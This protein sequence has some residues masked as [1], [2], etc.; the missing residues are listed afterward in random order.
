MEQKPLEQ[1]PIVLE[2]DIQVDTTELDSAIEKLFQLQSLM[3]QT[4]K[5]SFSL[6]C[7]DTSIS[8]IVE[9]ISAIQES[10]PNAEISVEVDL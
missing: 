2:A 10:Y 5:I 9:T 6:Y 4:Q 8:E 1:K 7:V 3:Q